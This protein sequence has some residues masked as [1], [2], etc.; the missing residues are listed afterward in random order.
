MED[1]DANS[2]AYLAI[3]RLAQMSLESREDLR[4]TFPF[5]APEPEPSFEP[6]SAAK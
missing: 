3:E 6:S 5:L 4:A 1:E 2:E